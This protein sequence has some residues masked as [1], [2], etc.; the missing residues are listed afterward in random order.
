MTINRDL[1]NKIVPKRIRKDNEMNVND[2][3]LMASLIM[4]I[5]PVAMFLSF[6]LISKIIATGFKTSLYFKTLGKKSYKG[7]R[8]FMKSPLPPVYAGVNVIHKNSIRN[9][10]R[11][12]LKKD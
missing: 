1:L 3:A 4:I 12:F 9:I 7:W 8:T 5:L 11:K 10:N 6:Y 2:F